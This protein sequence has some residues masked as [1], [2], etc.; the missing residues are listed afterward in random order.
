[1]RAQNQAMIAV[2]APRSV[3]ARFSTDHPPRYLNGSRLSRRI[4]LSFAV[5]APAGRR[6]VARGE[7]PHRRTLDAN[8]EATPDGAVLSQLAVPAPVDS[9]L[10]RREIGP[11]EQPVAKRKKCPEGPLDVGRRRQQC[12]ALEATSRPLERLL[13][14]VDEPERW[15]RTVGFL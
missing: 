2:T 11:I 10:N 12:V 5:F 9:A 13:A 8:K 15:L 1:M 3:A 7:V 14:L 6:Y 4:R